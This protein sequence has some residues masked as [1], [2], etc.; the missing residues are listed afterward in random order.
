MLVVP[1]PARVRFALDDAANQQ[2]VS[3]EPR[4]KLGPAQLNTERAAVSNSGDVA[5]RRA[6]GEKGNTNSSGR[7]TDLV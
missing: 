3:G 7:D 5:D 1:Q 2:F 4:K 6:A